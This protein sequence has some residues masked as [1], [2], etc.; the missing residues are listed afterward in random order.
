MFV[1][2][3]GRFQYL[4]CRFGLH[5]RGR[6]RP[7]APNYQRAR[8]SGC[9]RKMIRKPGEAWRLADPDNHSPAPKGEP[10]AALEPQPAIPQTLELPKW[11]AEIAPLATR[12]IPPPAPSRKSLRAFVTPARRE[13][14]A[15]QAKPKAAT[16][17][18]KA[19][20]ANAAEKAKPTKTVETPKAP[21]AAKQ[22]KAAISAKAAR[23]KRPK[24]ATQAKTAS[25]E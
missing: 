2:N 19:P 12:E 20:T 17:P 15:K 1:P 14:P 11:V 4:L 9:E 6:L 23:P 22:K 13:Q 3:V 8:C 5:R 7:P 18:K 25:P 21:A 16:K 10:D 24:P